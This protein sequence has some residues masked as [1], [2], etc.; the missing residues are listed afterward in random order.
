MWGRGGLQPPLEVGGSLGGYILDGV[1][2]EGGMAIVYRATRAADG[3]TVALKVLKGQSSGDSVYRRRFLHEAR[4][5]SEVR[6][7]NLVPL[8]DAGDAEGHP[9]LAVA[10]IEGR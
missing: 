7:P 3:A 1:L 5:A 9:Y 6:H 8:L 4:A 2:G 10:L